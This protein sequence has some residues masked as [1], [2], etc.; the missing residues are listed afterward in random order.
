MEE[1]GKILIEVKI[2]KNGTILNT[3]LKTKKPKRLAKAA[4]NLLKRKIQFPNPPSYL[5]EKKKF[6]TFEI[7][8]NFILK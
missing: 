1:E 8:I 7:P 6:F 5:F 3:K 2:N 4:E